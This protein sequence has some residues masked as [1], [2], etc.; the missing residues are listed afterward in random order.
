MTRTVDVEFPPLF[1]PLFEPHRYK[2]FYGGRGSGKSWSVAKALL[3]IGAQKKVRI[4]CTRE[5]QNSISDSVHRL[6]TDQI[7]ALGL[8]GFYEITQTAIRGRNGTEFIFSGL[9]HNSDKIKSFEGIDIAWVEE[10]DRITE[11]SWDILV[12]TI[13]SEGSEIW[14][15]FNPTLPSDHVYKLF[16][17]GEAPAGSV[18]VKVNWHDNPYFP[19][20]LK[21]EMEALRDSDPMKARHIW[22]GELLD[23]SNNQFIDLTRVIAAKQRH[24]E[25]R[26]FAM[27]PSLLGVDVARF[28]DDN[29]VLTHR[30]GNK[31]HEIRSFHRLDTMEVA[32]RAWEWHKEQR[33]AAILVDGIGVGAGVVDRLRQLD[34]PVIDV[35]VSS[36]PQD[37]TQYAN[38]RAELWGRMKGWL[39]FADILD[40]DSLMTDL[41]TPL[42][43]YDAH[44]RYLLEKKEDIKARGL[45]SP[46]FA[47]SLALTFAEYEIAKP[48]AAARMV[49]T[50]RFGN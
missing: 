24:L 15:T 25:P 38:L 45:S 20:E 47:E 44:L 9:R 48:R 35:V 36:A 32:A 12:P 3:V 27:F 10:A 2:V 26:E 31:V 29:S 49:Q 46:D 5:L 7:S 1:E 40:H 14:L 8:S 11:E 18:V 6:L 13:R 50:V 39:E 37:V 30:Q 22:D 21:A 43:R 19:A 28:G 4:L 23:M 34:L 41:V 17:H 33:F 42:Y 16:V